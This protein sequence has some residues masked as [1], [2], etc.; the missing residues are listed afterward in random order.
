MMNY[1]RPRRRKPHNERQGLSLQQ[2]AII[3]I[4]LL[5]AFL[6]AFLVV[7]GVDTLQR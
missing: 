5:A 6:V 3:L 4:T 7:A 1:V 2:C